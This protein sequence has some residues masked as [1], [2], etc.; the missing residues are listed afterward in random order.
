MLVQ[1]RI[2]IRAKLKE[3]NMSVKEFAAKLHTLPNKVER[4]L[5]GK[6]DNKVLE[7]KM[8]KYLDKNIK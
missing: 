6:D 2:I 4:I 1:D 5:C 8:F 3:R 7:E